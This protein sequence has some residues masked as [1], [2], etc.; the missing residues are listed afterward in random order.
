MIEIMLMMMIVIVVFEV[1]HWIGYGSWMHQQKKNVFLVSLSWHRWQLFEKRRRLI[2]Q[3]RIDGRNE[4]GRVYLQ[5]WNLG[6]ESIDW[7][8]VLIS[9]GCP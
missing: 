8:M 1:T 7:A 3:S 5:V 9:V 4:I 6:N 2:D